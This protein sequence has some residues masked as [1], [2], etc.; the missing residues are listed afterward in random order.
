MG[1]ELRKDPKKYMPAYF[2]NLELPKLK[3]M[4]LR[5]ANSPCS[6]AQLER[7]FSKVTDTLVP[8][9]SL[10]VDGTIK[11]LLV[12]AK[13]EQVLKFFKNFP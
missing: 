2:D 13:Y 5:M 4:Y 3:N 1:N 8:K 12:T 9:R 11:N 10:L 7:E 6:S